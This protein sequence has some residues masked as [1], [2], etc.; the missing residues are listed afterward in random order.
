MSKRSSSNRIKLGRRKSS[1]QLLNKLHTLK[2]SRR[3]PRNLYLLLISTRTRTRANSDNLLLNLEPSLIH[4]LRFNISVHAQTWLAT[5]KIKCCRKS[6]RWHKQIIWLWSLLVR[7][8][9]KLSSLS[10][11]PRLCQR[12]K[13]FNVVLATG[14]RLLLRRKRS[15]VLTTSTLMLVWMELIERIHP[16]EC[17]VRLI[18][19]NLSH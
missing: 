14:I 6:K 4:K 1:S 9:S 19:P 17:V 5:V 13:R 7:S 11:S 3:I 8:I 15:P 12:W 16:Y 18:I 2:P 10:L